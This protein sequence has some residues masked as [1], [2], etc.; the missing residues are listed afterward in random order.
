MK[1][2]YRLVGLG[3]A[4]CASKM[5]F[6]I[7]KLPAVNECVINFMT[8]KMTLDAEDSGF[9]SV[10]EQASKI[11]DNVEPGVRVVRA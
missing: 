7:N 10:F 3:C 6:A 8:T 5:E 4:D 9:D 11:I 1:R 2:Q